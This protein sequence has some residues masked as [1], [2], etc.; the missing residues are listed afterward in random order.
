MHDGGHGRIAP[1]A[2]SP[3]STPPIR[4]SEILEH[5][6][7]FD[8]L[9]EDTD[10]TTTNAPPGLWTSSTSSAWTGL[11]E[12]S[13]G[14]A[15]GPHAAF[16]DDAAERT[17]RRIVYRRGEASEVSAK[18]QRDVY[19]GFL[20]ALARTAARAATARA[21]ALRAAGRA[22]AATRAAARRSSHHSSRRC[23]RRRSSRRSSRSRSSR[24]R[25]SRCCR[26]SRRSSRRR[27]SRHSSL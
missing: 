27:S 26:S 25:R 9:N 12:V 2:S 5:E 15:G 6:E 3:I 14:V 20:D 22:R 7:D 11:Y 23:S 8:Y 18:A 1:P 17:L 16:A 24:C 13:G 21:G 10:G 4:C 19:L